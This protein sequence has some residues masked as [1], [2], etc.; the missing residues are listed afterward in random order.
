MSSRILGDMDQLAQVLNDPAPYD[1][2][3]ARLAVLQ[4]TSRDYLASVFSK[5]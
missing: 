2:F 3:R 5:D 1:E 4:K